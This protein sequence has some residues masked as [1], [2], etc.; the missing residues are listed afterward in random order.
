[1]ERR[2]RS[3]RSR[4]GSR[5]GPAPARRDARLLVGT[6]GLTLVAIV[7]VYLFHPHAQP[8]DAALATAPRATSPYTIFGV[9]D[10]GMHCY[11]KDYRAFL[12]LP[13]ANTLKVQV[14]K[15]TAEDATLVTKG[16]T[17]SFK[18]A[19]NTSSAGKTNFWKFAADYGFK[20]KP[21]VGIT[22]TRLA[23]KMHLSADKKFW[24]AEYIPVTPYDDQGHWDPLQRAIV[25]VKDAA[26]GKVLATQKPIVLPVS[27][28][29]NCALCHGASGAPRNILRAHDTNEGTTLLADLNAGTRHACSQCH[30][31]NVLGAPGKPGVL[32]LSEAMH[33]WHADKMDPATTAGLDTPCYAC[34][35]GAK[36]RCLRGAMAAVGLTCTD[37]RCHGTMQHVADTQAAG[38]QAWLQEPRCQTCHGTK[39]AE[40][41]NTLYRNS[42][43]QNGPE[44]MNGRIMCET[45]HN[46]THAEWPSMRNVDNRLPVNVQGLPTYIRRCSACHQPEGGGI[47][48]NAGG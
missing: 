9:N 22:G 27:D 29:M 36:T 28:E 32:P 16:I 17:V 19:N 38:R 13:P 43:L 41:A 20:V 24:V 23:G 5:A 10:L 44:G 48:G 30:A 7:G 1:M 15:R 11:Q 25:T 37:P 35:P 42:Y 6:L 45:C 40:N 39:Y 21:N 8:A 47:H 4:R 3:R 2:L 46:S 33:A 18:I 31:D 26:T 14:F 12:I 34:H